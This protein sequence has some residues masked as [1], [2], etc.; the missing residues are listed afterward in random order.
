MNRKLRD[1]LVATGIEPKAA[2]VLASAIPDVTALDD[3]RA[4]MHERFDE[5]EAT[6]DREFARQRRIL[7]G[8]ALLTIAAIVVSAILDGSGS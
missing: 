5:F 2:V 4:H 3:L 6:I 8:L 7:T 1:D